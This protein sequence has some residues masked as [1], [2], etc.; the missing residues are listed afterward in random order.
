MI[1]VIVQVKKYVVVKE[2]NDECNTIDVN[3]KTWY[4]YNYGKDV[5]LSYDPNGFCLGRESLSRKI[6][7]W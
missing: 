1:S 6:S 2:W 7:V 5:C 4:A 3:F